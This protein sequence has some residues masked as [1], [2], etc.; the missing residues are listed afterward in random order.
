MAVSYPLQR[1]R[2]FA[3][4]LLCAVQMHSAGVRDDRCATRSGASRC[5]R[6]GAQELETGESAIEKLMGHLDEKK[7]ECLQ[8]TFRDVARHFREVFRELVKDGRGDLI[9]SYPAEGEDG[10]AGAAAGP[11]GDRVYTGVKVR[12]LRFASVQGLGVLCKVN[13][14]SSG[15]GLFKVVPLSTCLGGRGTATLVAQVESTPVE[16]TRRTMIGCEWGAIA[17]LACLWR[18]GPAES[19]C[20]HI[21]AVAAARRS[22]CRSGGTKR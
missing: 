14:Q 18:S 6:G 16:C 4:C 12:S 7:E 3:C 15:A 2:V 1:A 22:R 8:R 5:G 10:N 13:L 9:M 21:T 17:S 11:A 19:R 20:G